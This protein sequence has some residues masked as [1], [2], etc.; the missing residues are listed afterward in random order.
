ME[1]NFQDE[2]EQLKLRNEGVKILP[3]HNNIPCHKPLPSN[4]KDK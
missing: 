4:Y 3:G 1:R 2:Y